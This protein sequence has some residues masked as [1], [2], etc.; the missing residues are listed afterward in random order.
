[1]PKYLIRASYTQEGVQGLLKE[2]GTKR[3]QVV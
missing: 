3:R 2:G 1:M